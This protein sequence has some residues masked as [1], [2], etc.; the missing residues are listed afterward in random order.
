MAWSA[1]IASAYNSETS[2][3]F[4]TN[5]TLLRRLEGVYSYN[6][7]I[8][9]PAT[10]PTIAAGSLTGLSGA[11]NAK[12][13]YARKEDQAVVCESNPGV[14]ATAAVTLANQSLS[15]TATDPD[16]E[17]V[18]CIRFYRTVAGSSSYYYS[19]ELNYCN[20]Q[21]AV[22]YDWEDTD[23]YISGV[24]YRFS[25]E[26][27][28]FNRECC[29]FWELIYSRYTLEDETNCLTGIADNELVFNDNHTDAEL[30]ALAHTDNNPPPSKA[31]YVFGPTANGTLFLIKNHQ[32]YYNKPQQPEYWPSSYYI[33]VS[34]MQFP[35]VCGTI[36]NTQPFVFDKREIYYLAGTQFADLPNMTTFR[37]YPQS[38]KA[39]TVS[40]AGVK[41]VL[42]LGIFHVGTD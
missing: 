41:A 39:G 17:Q 5:G 18:N 11:Y 33:D 24:P 16:D 7:G 10:I 34:A 26:D 13:S 14:S 20:R 27:S 28:V 8:D 40:A 38:A 15:I 36:Y 2:T 22:A 6:W 29:Y 30:G 9:A 12:Y 3:V 35:L 31:S 42:G 21:H 32:V 23:N 1:A 19:G 37:P 25:Y 4:A